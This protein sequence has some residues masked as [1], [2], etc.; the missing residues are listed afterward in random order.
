MRY[1]LALLVILGTLSVV[2][3]DEVER[4]LRQF[5]RDVAQRRMNEALEEQAYQMRR[6]A[7]EQRRNSIIQSY[8]PNYYYHSP[9]Y[10]GY[11]YY[12]PYY[13]PQPYISGVQIYS[14]W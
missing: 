8:G 12:Q 1:A 7:N 2:R 5:D 6:M 13:Y 10:R 4:A 14:P 9:Y 11:G 3:G